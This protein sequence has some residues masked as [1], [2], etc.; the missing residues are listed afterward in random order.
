MPS[1][2]SV[3][4][5][6]MRT[7]LIS[8]ARRVVVKVGSNVLSDR[9][10]HLSER[11]I[12]DLARQVAAARGGGRETV[13]VTSG[14]I[15]AGVAQLGLASR[16]K[17][18]PQLQAA[19]AVGQSRLMQLYAAAFRREGLEVGQILLTAEDLK[20][21]TRHLN[22][23]NTII[24]LLEKGVVP[25]INE[26]DTVSTDE[27][28]FG[29][30]DTLSA[31]VANLVA[32][33]L[34]VILTD[35]RGLMTEDPRKGKGELIREVERMT[36]GIETLAR[37]AGSARGTGGMA[38]KLRAVKMV[39]SSGEAA[40]I[41]DGREREILCRILRGEDVGTFFHPAGAKMDGRKRWIAWFV[42]PRGTLIVDDGAAAALLRKGTSLLPS[43]IR[44]VLG[45]F[46]DGDT[47]RVT[48]ADGREIARG[49]SNYSA[50][51][52]RVIRGRKTGEIAGLLGHKDYDEAVHR[53][54]LVLMGGRETGGG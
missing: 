52:L 16:P 21:R 29:D 7:Q 23:R 15:S 19:A 36:P 4:T 18:L 45:E 27:I 6:N 26:N 40:V 20:A 42:K 22:A 48:A 54:N 28:K 24:A 10:G 11:V 5:M 17:L 44:D 53:D 3:A 13:L 1:V 51:D 46:R 50:A 33:D 2:I 30:N 43:G 9:T 39:V 38:S 14:A 34:L 12:G 35:T 37:G 32:A 25:I 47:V 49:L 41:A 8:K 31:L